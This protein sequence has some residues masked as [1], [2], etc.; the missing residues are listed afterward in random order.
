[1][2]ETTEGE[3]EWL[4][5]FYATPNEA[6]G[7]FEFLVGIRA[8]FAFFSH[9]QVESL[10]CRPLTCPIDR[11]KSPR[12]QRG[13]NCGR[14]IVC[15]ASEGLRVLLWASSKGPE[16]VPVSGSSYVDSLWVCDLFRGQ[17]QVYAACLIPA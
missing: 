1:M 13:S 12:L 3:K 4:S 11:D 9:K 8:F 10:K 7:F 5:G 16:G 2:W 6:L 15:A 14:G 17:L